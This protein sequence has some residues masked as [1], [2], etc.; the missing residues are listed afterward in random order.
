MHTC[1][2]CGRTDFPSRQSFNAHCRWCTEY[3]Q[4]TQK[5]TT[6][7]GTCL[8]QA[9]PKA[10]P[11]Q[12]TSPPTQSPPLPHTNDPLAPFRGVLRLS[13]EC[14]W[15]FHGIMGNGQGRHR[16]VSKAPNAHGPI[17]RDRH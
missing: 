17:L 11:D 10:Q 3:R 9:V 6:A 8:R 4:H 5:Q 13:W 16:D 15:E 2:C 1:K 14:G 12:T 7:S